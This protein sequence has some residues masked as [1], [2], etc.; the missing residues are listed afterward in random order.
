MSELFA[1]IRKLFLS[2]QKFWHHK[3]WSAARLSKTETPARK[4][5]LLV[6][7][8]LF[9]VI[10]GF[11]RERIKLRAAALT[12]VSL[13]SLVPALAVVFSVFTAFGGL[14]EVEER[15]R[16]FIV[17][18]LS[19]TNQEV[20]SEY[21]KMFVD[22][23]HAGKIGTVGVSVLLFTVISLLGNIEKSFNDI[24]GLTKDRSILQ[25]FQV[26]W[27][28][29]TLGPIL[30]GVS[31]SVT[32]AV[33]ASDIAQQLDRSIP[34]VGI[35]GSLTPLVLTSTFFTFLYII[36]PNTQV[37]FRAAIIGG[38]VA[39]SLWVAAQK[40][41]AIYAS[42]AITYSAIYGSLGAVPL[43]IIWLYVSWTVALLGA[44]LTFAVQ[45]AQ[46]Y[47]PETE[48]TKHIP[49]RDREFIA[50]RL[51]L[52][53]S[54]HFSAGKGPIGAQ[55]LVDALLVPPRPAR[56]VLGELVESGLLIESAEQ[57]GQESGYLPGRPLQQTSVADVVRVMRHG[58]WYADDREFWQDDPFSEEVNRVLIRGEVAVKKV[59]G[60]L[61]LDEL[62]DLLT[63]EE[64]ER[65]PEE[66][67][68]APSAVG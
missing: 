14:Q 59:L 38:L 56:M 5:L 40:L 57:R 8:I 28:L 11:R 60:E 41:Y 4:I 25:R 15:L 47:E 27:P 39:G 3:L 17:E 20:V 7:R 54:K 18:A 64:Q 19:V 35:V 37:P 26:Y 23:T 46:T 22:K 16:T 63:K 62:T 49:Q 58:Q 21:L 61:M 10:T 45:S 29:I 53:V 52:A 1:K 2:I 6:L 9:I 65:A 44:S 32:A 12:Y 36:M 31:L 34:Y 33:E 24:W 68:E 43:F 13:L 51:L 67:E 66:G 55:A 42:R 48:R 30:L 50:V